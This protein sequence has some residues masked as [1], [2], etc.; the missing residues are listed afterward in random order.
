MKGF[1][2]DDS[3]LDR[4]L[5][6]HFARMERPTGVSAGFETRL[7][8]KL[9]PPPPVWRNY[10]WLLGLYTAAAIAITVYALIQRPLTAE[11][12]NAF[13]D[14]PITRL[15]G[16]LLIPITLAAVVWLAIRAQSGWVPWS[17]LLRRQNS[18]SSSSIRRSS[19]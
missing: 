19:L 6:D 16:A 10:G 18:R 1:Q 9:E 15:A 2:P 3:E 7:R 17:R 12:W 14:N 5:T 4:M 13:L 8:K 11:E